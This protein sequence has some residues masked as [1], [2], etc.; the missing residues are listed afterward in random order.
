MGAMAEAD[1]DRVRGMGEAAKQAEE[2]LKLFK[3]DGPV[4]VDSAA[5]AA[6]KEAE[7][8]KMAELDEIIKGL[9]GKDNK[10]AR[11]EKE[12]EKKAI[13][14]S[15]QYIDAEKI[16]KGKEPSNGFFVIKKE[17]EAAAPAATAAPVVEESTA[18]IRM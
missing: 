14:D 12:K 7:D 5:A 2:G 17:Q 9:T 15:K 3:E 11:T 16:A 10:K 6:F 4:E 18:E 1:E 13:K 8:A